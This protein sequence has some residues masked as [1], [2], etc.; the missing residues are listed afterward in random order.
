MMGDFQVGPWRVQPRLNSISDAGQVRHLEPKVMQVLV[1]LA[2]RAGDVVAKEELLKAVWP[3][4]FVGD[5]ALLR[6]ISDLRKALEDDAKEPRY[7]QTIPKR[8]YRLIAD[9]KLLDT[10][11]EAES[12]DRPGRR[13]WAAIAG[14]AVLAILGTAWLVQRRPRE[15]SGAPTRR[16]MLAVLPFENLSADPEQ[17]FFS[18]GLTDE[19]ITQLARLQ[20]ERLGVIARSSAMQYKRASKTIEQIARELGVDYV[21]EGTVRREAERVRI[22]VQ[23]VQVR[24]ESHLWAENYDRQLSG[25]LSLQAEVA[26]AVAGRIRL[27]LGSSGAGEPAASHPVRSEAYLAYLLGRHHWHRLTPEDLELAAKHFERAV[28]LDPSFARAWLGLSDSYRHLGSWW[29]DWP[30]KKA[31]PLAKEAMARALKLDTTLAEAHGSLGWIHFVYDWDWQRAE[32]EFKRGVD[33]NPYARDAVSPYANF[34]RRMKRLEEARQQAQRAV[35]ADPLS[36]LEV[37]EAARV[38]LDLG[39]PDEA[40]ALLQRVSETA[41]A[42]RATLLALAQAHLQAGRLEKAI[43]FLERASRTTFRDRL[44]LPMLGTAY[45]RAGRLAEARRVLSQLLT[46]PTVAQAAIAELYASLG[47]KEQAMRW[48]QKG[49]QER[50]PRMVWLR[51][52]AADHPLWGDPRFQELIGRMRFPE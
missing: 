1:A 10:A 49:Y 26:R 51:L 35:E 25:I 8:G 33:L 17:E 2:D 20:P 13:W 12:Q 43:E 52:Y 9:V 14:L 23:L 32:A 28:H 42:S 3:D 48:W 40:E 44:A 19:M 47:E 18:D 5:D 50:D 11:R 36:P 34:L 16:I 41:P 38:Y 24:D 31:F 30:P 39:Q 22:T 6:C 46:T 27:T 37:T 29:G 45:A 21:I 7:L 15:Q 4:T